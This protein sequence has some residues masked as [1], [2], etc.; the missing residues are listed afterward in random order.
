MAKPGPAKG[1]GGRPRQRAPQGKTADGYRMKTVGPPSQGKRVYAHRAAAGVTGA[2][3]DTTVDHVNNKRA[4]N[5]P[6]NLKVVTRAANT[7]KA[8]KR[9]AKVQPR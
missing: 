6:S 4:D 1:S 9:R 3:P 7:A 8:N 5:R 2:G